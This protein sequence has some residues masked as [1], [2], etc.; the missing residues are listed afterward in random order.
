MVF[1]VF[2]LSESKQKMSATYPHLQKLWNGLK[3]QPEKMREAHGQPV[4]IESTEVPG[5]YGVGMD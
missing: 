4:W 1:R 2:G 5:I 3:P